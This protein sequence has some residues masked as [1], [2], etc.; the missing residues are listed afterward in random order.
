[1]NGCFERAG[2][3]QQALRLLRQF[4]GVLQRESLR[5]DLDSKYALIFQRYTADLEAVCFFPQ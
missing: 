1:M 5:A 2:S 4:R 3:T